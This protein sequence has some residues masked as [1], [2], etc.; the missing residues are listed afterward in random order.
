MKLKLERVKGIEPSS[1]AWEA[2]ILPLNHTRI[3]LVAIKIFYLAQQITSRKTPSR[4]MIPD[5]KNL[6]RRQFVKTSSTFLGAAMLAPSLVAENASKDSPPK[7]R[8]IKKAMM[9]GTVPGGGS[10][11]DKFELIKEAGF[12]GVEPPSGLDNA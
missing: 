3:R 1:Q 12:A 2:H 7:K 8:D 5:F 4:I 6:S 9:L 11:A 10:L